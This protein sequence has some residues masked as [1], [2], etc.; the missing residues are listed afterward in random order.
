MLVGAVRWPLAL[1]Q[2]IA[3]SRWSESPTQMQQSDL[4]VVCVQPP[5]RAAG[6]SGTKVRLVADWFGRTLAGLTDCAARL[7]GG[8]C[9]VCW[10]RIQRSAR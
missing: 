5:N 7:V 9:G 1:V 8:G 6:F 3:K 10:F 4:T 2:I